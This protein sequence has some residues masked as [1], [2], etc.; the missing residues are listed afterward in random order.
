MSLLVVTIF[1]LAHYKTCKGQQQTKQRKIVEC[2]NQTNVTGKKQK[3]KEITVSRREI[4]NTIEIDS[5]VGKISDSDSSG[6][7]SDP[8]HFFK[9]SR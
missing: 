1:I 5:D 4:K 9:V 8:G 3:R 7:W 6:K 2:I